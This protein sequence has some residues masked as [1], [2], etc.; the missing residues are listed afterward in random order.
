MRVLVAGSTGYIGKYV[1]KELINRGYNV[2]AFAREKSGVGGKQSRDQTQKVIL[3]SMPLLL[4]TFYKIAILGDKGS[5]YRRPVQ[6]VL[7]LSCVSVMALHQA[8]L[9]L[10]AV[11]T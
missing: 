11:Y 5:V 10:P 2:V 1:T 3:T 4:R 9:H 6:A 8:V 7:R